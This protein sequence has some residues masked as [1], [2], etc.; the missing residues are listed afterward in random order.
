MKI[1][2]NLKIGDQF[3]VIEKDGIFKVGEIISLKED[4]ESN[5]PYF[6]NAD[7]SDYWSISFS[8]LEPLTKSVRDAR[9]D[10]I[11]IG[12]INRF[13]HMVLERGQSTVLL[14]CGNDFKKAYIGNHTFDELEEY[15]ALK[16]EPVVVDDKTAE[17]IKLLKEA[18]YKISK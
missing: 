4:D 7:R 11:V 3:R 15:F 13:E 8:Y 14:S 6:W 12:K 16:D 18:G 10:D 2:T 5:C 1:P 17:A 9:V